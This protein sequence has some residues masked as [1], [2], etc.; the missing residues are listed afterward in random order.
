MYII[1]ND[2]IDK[3]TVIVVQWSIIPPFEKGI[4]I[5][6]SKKGGSAQHYMK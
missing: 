2:Q 6:C 3:G 1:C 5:I 4:F